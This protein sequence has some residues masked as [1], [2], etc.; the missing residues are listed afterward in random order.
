MR[1]S[2]RVSCGVALVIIGI[3]YGSTKN[4]VVAATEGGYIFMK[5]WILNF[6]GGF[7]YEKDGMECAA[8]TWFGRSSW[9]VNTN[10]VWTGE[11][12]MSKG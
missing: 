3:F 4:C 9:L 8:Q 11:T 1:G 6:L 10:L 12:W 7:A 5:L 2:T